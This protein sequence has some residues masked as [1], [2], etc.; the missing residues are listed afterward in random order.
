MRFWTAVPILLLS[1]GSLNAQTLREGTP[2]CLDA[3]AL[4][5]I[6]PAIRRGET[7]DVVAR[8]GGACF[9]LAK[10]SSVAVIRRSQE[11]AEVRL[12]AMAG[13]VWVMP[14]HLPS[15]A[16]ETAQQHAH[17]P[18][19]PSTA[20]ADPQTAAAAT[21]RPSGRKTGPFGLYMGMT[22]AELAKLGKLENREPGV[23]VIDPVPQSHPDFES[24]ML[25]V[26]ERHGLCRIMAIGKTISTNVYGT[27]ITAKFEQI[28]DAI[29]SKYGKR[30]NFD[31]LNA[32]SIWNE[33][34]D[35]MM[36]VLKEE[37]TLASYW[38]EEI[39]SNLV[40]QVAAIGLKVMALSDDSAYLTLS[41]DFENVDPCVEDIK[42]RANSVF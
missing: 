10:N 32:G 15:S 1:A 21:P 24:Y 3:P 33:P 6:A 16:G 41:Y 39:G 35:W 13:T 20:T 42:S 22:K 25:L 14:E 23:F 2:V 5:K 4:A 26:S 17:P 38:N 40:D 11:A 18:V 9:S 19:T 7:I 8:A 36:A 28:R 31:F 29:S 34:R 12:G 37:R 27:A 30:K